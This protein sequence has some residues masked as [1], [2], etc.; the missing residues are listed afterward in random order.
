M[1]QGRVKK[2][3]HGFATLFGSLRQLLPYLL[4]K[5]KYKLHR[6]PH[7][8]PPQKKKTGLAILPI[9]N[10]VSLLHLRNLCS[11]GKFSPGLVAAIEEF[12]YVS[13]PTNYYEHS[14]VPTLQKGGTH[15]GFDDSINHL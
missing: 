12:L 11:Q 13:M 7:S 3:P 9:V 8:L 4:V 14:L 15:W 2:I 5:N 6:V 10:M 1:L